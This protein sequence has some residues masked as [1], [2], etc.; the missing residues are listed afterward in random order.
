MVGILTHDLSGNEIN[1]SYKSREDDK[2]VSLSIYDQK[3]KIITTLTNLKE[4]WNGENFQIGIYTYRLKA[5]NQENNEIELMGKV[6][7]VR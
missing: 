2:F 6:M 4:S 3:G 1:F 5:K 7:L